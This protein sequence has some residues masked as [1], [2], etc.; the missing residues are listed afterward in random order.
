MSS[1]ASLN[2]GARG[3]R[4]ALGQLLSMW[5]ALPRSIRRFVA[6]FAAVMAEEGREVPGRLAATAVALVIAAIVIVCGWL[7]LC[8]ATAAW[9]VSAQAW[10]WE[11]ALYVIAVVN[12]AIAA[13]AILA[14]FRALK[15]PFFPVTTYELHRLRE[16]N[17]EHAA[18][19]ADREPVPEAVANAGPR[20]RALIRSEADL[21]ARLAEVRRATPLLI[22]T[23]SV[24][25]ATAGVGFAVGFITA[26]PRARRGGTAQ[27]QIPVPFTRQLLNLAFGQL[28]SLAVAAA[29]RQFQRGAGDDRSF[30]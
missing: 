27:P 28:S 25:A 18:D 1:P 7:L 13:I 9:L 21:A 5:A 17:H 4:T 30:Y 3:R 2:A 19:Q 11:M 6:D 23:P 14:A 15:S 24:I 12:L 22:A 16:A 10:R 26:K 8:I 29:L 20:E